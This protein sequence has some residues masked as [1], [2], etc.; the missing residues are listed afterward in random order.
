MATIRHGTLVA[1]T[2]T[3][4]TFSADADTIDTVEVINRSGSAEIFFTVD[5]T[6]PTVA[7]NDCEILPA[8]VGA[9][10]VGVP[11]RASTVVKLISAGAPTYSVRAG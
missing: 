1:A 9:V 11:G 7:G 4:V 8:A 6:T 3:T 2:V 10:E 5:G